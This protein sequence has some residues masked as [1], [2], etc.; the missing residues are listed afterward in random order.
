MR[1]VARLAPPLLLLAAGIAAWQ[2][3][4]VARN[5]PDYLLPPPS[6]IWQTAIDERE[7]LWQNTIPTVKIA[8]GGFLLALTLGLVIAVLIRYSRVIE[9]ALYPIVIVSQTVPILALAPILVVILGFTI[10]PKLVVVCLVCF[11]PITVNTVDGLKSV[12]PELVNLMR[13]MGAGRW[14]LFREVE[15]PSALPYVFSGARVAITYSVIGAI[16]GEW[17]GSS[18]GLGWYM[19]QAKDQLD[20]AGLFAAMIILTLIGICLFAAVSVV[21]RLL[22]P[23][24][25]RERRGI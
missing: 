5:V 12:D 3:I 8:V 21:E 9:L 2:I 15:W 10:L 17:V 19:I 16:F 1:R 23:W 13:T 11:F 4:T 14:R 20:T 24:Y 18:E 7:L 25:R 6:D 22:L